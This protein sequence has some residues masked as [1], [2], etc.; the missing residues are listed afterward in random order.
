[1]SSK[2]E[3]SV[4]TRPS[5]LARLK[6]WSQQTAWREFDHDYAPLFRNVAR[7]AGL[8][9]AEADEVAQDTLIGVS[10]KIVEFHHAANRGSFRAWLY[11]QARW[12]IADQFRARKK[13][14]PA[15]AAN[16]RDHEPK[17]A[18]LESTLPASLANLGR[19]EAPESRVDAVFE[20]IW[21]AEW[22]EHIT[23]SA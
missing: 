7:K 15:G 14:V 4:A 12:R 10:K 1:M 17:D 23:N 22:T 2:T 16:S 11:Q 21:D 6:D 18:E 8:T 5:L 20:R 3:S 9:D 19:M 13:S